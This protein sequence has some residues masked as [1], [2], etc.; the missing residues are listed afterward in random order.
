MKDTRARRFAGRLWLLAL[1]LL[2][3]C[4]QDMASQPS[5]R[6]DQPSAFFPKGRVARPLVKGTVAR[7]HLRTDRHLFAGTRPG[8]LGAPALAGTLVAAG[9][10]N[11]LAA[12]TTM[13]SAALGEEESGVDT[14]PFPITAEVLRHGRNRY[15]I[16]CVVCHDAL[17]TGHGIIVERGYTPP[18]SYHRERLRTATVGHFYQ[19]ITKGY[20]SMPSYR[21]QVPPRDR[22]AIIAYI[23]ALQ[24]SQHFPSRDLTEDMRREWEKQ[25]AAAAREGGPQP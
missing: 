1:C 10:G 15:M 9:S 22:W 2:P 12:L 14:F 17:G 7:G 4:Q 8:E 18:P 6:P 21:K 25:R 5:Y 3:A 23:R 13:S 24:L 20:G 11:L 16:Y 19:V